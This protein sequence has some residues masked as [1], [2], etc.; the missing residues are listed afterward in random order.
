MNPMYYFCLHDEL[1][2]KRLDL[3]NC[4]IDKKEMNFTNLGIDSKYYPIL[5]TLLK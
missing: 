4:L 5:K 1:F 2:P 3:S